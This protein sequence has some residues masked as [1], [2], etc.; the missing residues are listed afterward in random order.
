LHLLNEQQRARAKIETE[1]ALFKDLQVR[2]TLWLPRLPQKQ[3]GTDSIFDI[4]AEDWTQPALNTAQRG[5]NYDAGLQRHIEQLAQRLQEQ[6]QRGRQ[7]DALIAG[8]QRRDESNKRRR[9]EDRNV[10]ERLESR[11]QEQ[12]QQSRKDRALI[13]QLQERCHQWSRHYNSKEGEMK[14]LQTQLD[15]LTHAYKEQRQEM[16]QL[17][18]VYQ[19]LKTENDKLRREKRVLQH[20]THSLHLK[21]N[22]LLREN[23]TLRDE[24]ENA[25]R[26]KKVVQQ[27]CEQQCERLER[28]LARIK[29][30]RDSWLKY[31]R[32]LKD[33]IATQSA[34]GPTSF[35]SKRSSRHDS[36]S[37]GGS[38]PTYVARSRESSKERR[39]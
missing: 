14:R 22:D 30:E 7:A 1:E 19:A 12:E 39:T 3:T 35:P 26:T 2:A 18:Q 21:N 28:E 37:S 23:K 15:R 4:L 33:R 36:Y 34:M 25:T 11:L 6:E 32:N 29:G 13:V 5:T 24:N 31:A 27:R 17:Q 8:L 10:I 38:S 20:E 16:Q 9:Q